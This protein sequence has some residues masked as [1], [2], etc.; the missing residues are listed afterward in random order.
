MKIRSAR[1]R[2]FTLIELL[3]VIAIIAILVALLLPAVQQA[4]EAARRTQCKNNLKQLGLALHNYHDIHN[5]FV[6]RKGGTRGGG[7]SSRLDG[8]YDRRSGMISLLPFL[9]QAPLYNLIEAGDTST[10]PNVPPGG[11]APWGSWNVWHKQIPGLRCPSDPG[12]ATSRGTSS[13]AFSM[14]DYVGAAN[15][16]ATNVNGL[17][18]FRTTYGMRHITDGTSNTVALSER[19]QASF[20][21]NGKSNATIK[22]GILTNVPAISSN[23]GACLAAAAAVSNGDRYQ[24]GAG[25]KGRFS[26]AWQDGQPENVAF[27]TII[28]P[29]GP[30]CIDNADPNADGPINLMTAS[31]HHTGG[32]QVLMADG[33]VRFISDSIDT[34]NLGVSTTLGA[35]SPYGVWGALG[36]KSGGEVVGE[37]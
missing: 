11:A 33:A 14:G 37:F 24:S 9:D 3:V 18:A 4:R 1:Q 19:V 6:Y 28:A 35:P 27:T 30:S 22:E 32:V 29:N 7:D 20:G 15:R 8:N 26:H 10:S 34:G 12:I 23:P 5:S 2:G 13:Y 21:I 25:V 16:D 31:S 36:T 17:F